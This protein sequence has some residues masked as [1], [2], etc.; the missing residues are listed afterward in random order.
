M[1]GPGAPLLHVAYGEGFAL[2]LAT[3]KGSSSAMMTFTIG[4]SPG[5]CLLGAFLPPIPGLLACVS[6]CPDGVMQSTRAERPG[7]SGTS[8]HQ[9][10]PRGQL[11]REEAGPLLCW[12]QRGSSR[13]ERDQP[14]DLCDLFPAPAAHTQR[15]LPAP[16]QGALVGSL[17]FQRTPRAGS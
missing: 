2:A 12:S 11:S 15:P 5:L 14:N 3:L 1:M 9:G 6:L 8:Y 10:F 7:P 17:L 16:W 13:W 4:C